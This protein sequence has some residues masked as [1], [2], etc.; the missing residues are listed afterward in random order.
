MY[1]YIQEIIFYIIYIFYYLILFK[2]F[3][4]PFKLS[5]F[6]ILFYYKKPI[7]IENQIMKKIVNIDKRI[8][9]NT[10]IKKKTIRS[11]YTIFLHIIN[12]TFYVFS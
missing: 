12:N 10:R 3:S 9:S 7:K 2:K 4:H 1:I 8:K 11:N 6:N 5:L